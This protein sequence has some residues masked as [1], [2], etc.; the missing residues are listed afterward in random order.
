MIKR[1][2]NLIILSVML[3][4]PG[5]STAPHET[6]T[7]VLKNAHVVT[8]DETAPTAEAVAIRKN[9]IVFVGTN[10]AV[11]RWIGLQTRVEDAQGMWIYPGFVDAH[12]H[13]SGLGT[14]LEN[15]D[16][17]GTAS[18]EEVIR[19][20]RKRAAKTP[21]GQWILGRGWDQNDWEKMEFPTHEKL[22]RAIPDHPVWLTRVDGHAGLANAAAMALAGV[23][24][25]TEDPDGG[26]IVR[27]ESGNPTGV[28]IDNAELL[29][30]QT[31][32]EAGPKQRQARL[33]RA[34][35]ACRQVGLTGVHDAGITPE[36]TKDYQA[37]LSSNQLGL[38]VYAML[39]APDP[40]TDAVTYMRENRVNGSDNALFT[41]RSLK[42]YAD[43]AL[44]SRG[45]ALL[46]PYSD[47]PGNTGLLVTPYERMVQLADAAVEAGFQ[48]CAHAIGDRAN[49]LVLDAYREALAGQEGLDHRFRIEHA[50]ILSPADIPRF[51]EMGVIP[52]MQPTHATSDMP[53]AVDRLGEERLTGAY[54]WR[55]LLDTGVVIPCGSDFPVESHNPML[56]IYA[57]VTRQDLNGHPEGGWYP[58]Q[59]M[60][61]MEAVKGFTTWA[62]HTA[63]QEDQLG[64]I[65]VGMLADLTVL[66]TDLLNCPVKQIPGATALMTIVNGRIL[67]R[68]QIR[69]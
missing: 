64:M 48:I 38:R 60:T 11:T 40:E 51:S 29:I 26:R 3:W 45:A 62:A 31:I 6:A 37:L 16:L 28:F 43:G 24:A 67:Y 50:Q 68:K 52:S 34:A 63:F 19:R 69:P 22:S 7:L 21:E 25:R 13:V 66:D 49:R 20:V 15:V 55:S 39:E 42:M 33:K 30:Q 2:L 4:T 59:R 8:M 9:R 36:R 61:R 47:D 58:D 18:Y 10:D 41:I 27:D 5:C 65:R 32:P 12:C 14:A 56:G 46:D 53:W 57:A 1:S 23:S 54:A 17:V 35:E 44:G